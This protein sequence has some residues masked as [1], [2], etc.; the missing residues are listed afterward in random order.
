M[1]RKKPLPK[2]LA[3]TI[4]LVSLWLGSSWQPLAHATPLI[5]LREVQNCDG[6]H[7]GGRSQK[8]FLLRRCSLDCVGCHVDPAG[9]GARNEWGFY[10]S[11]DQMAMVNFLQP[12]DPLRDESRFDAHVDS[13][14]TLQKTATDTHTFPMSTEFNF[15]LKPFK[16][17]LSVAYTPLLLGKV[18][19]PLFRIVNE[20]DRRFRERYAVMIDKIPLNTYVRAYRGAPMYGLRRPNHTL[21]IREKIGLGPYATTDAVDVGGTPN[22]PYWRVSKM[23]GDP[24]V[25]QDF[26]QQG[27]SY[28]GGF[29]GVT[30]GW[31]VNVSGWQTASATHEVTM[32]A[33]GYG[34]NAFGLLL[35]SETNDRQVKVLETATATTEADAHKVHPSNKIS[36]HTVAFAGILGVM[37]G[38]IQEN[39]EDADGKSQRINYFLDLHPIPFFQFELWLRRESGLRDLSDTLMIFHLYGDF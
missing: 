27:Q 7:K 34:I 14:I 36:E 33:V 32:N 25:P 1:P 30:L 9:A 39:Y 26:R 35:Y 16:D 22:V 2:P 29:R 28:H 11:H 31:H 37:F 17:Y 13:R 23:T 8:P 19:D 12:I 24:Y 6:C 4:L 15:R 10:Y 3:A 18:D 21:W 20:G 38:A 5:A